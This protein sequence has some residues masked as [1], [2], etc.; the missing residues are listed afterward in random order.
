MA[1]LLTIDEVQAIENSS[2]QVIVSIVQL[3]ERRKG[4][5]LHQGKIIAKD[6]IEEYKK[7]NGISLT[8]KEKGNQEKRVFIGTR[9]YRDRFRSKNKPPVIIGQTR[10]IYSLMDFFNLP[11]DC[12][13]IT[14]M[15]VREWEEELKSRRILGII[16]DEPNENSF[17]GEQK[18]DIVIGTGDATL[19]IK[20]DDYVKIE[21][22]KV[23]RLSPDEAVEE[24]KRVLISY[25]ERGYTQISELI[26]F[27]GSDEWQSLSTDEKIRRIK[28]Y[29]KGIN[30]RYQESNTPRKEEPKGL[31]YEL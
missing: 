12:V 7:S 17:L 8:L 14:P 2:G 10:L 22:D 9:R 23:K 15:I 28:K 11:S 3:M 31:N 16:T 21:G 27:M 26:E 4:F 29:L 5:Y 20:N 18:N 30:Q 25:Q 1:E 13:V 6:E 19:Y 24:Y